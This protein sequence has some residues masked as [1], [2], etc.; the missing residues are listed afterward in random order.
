M[1]NPT[2]LVNEVLEVIQNPR[3]RE[4]I[5]RRFGLKD[6]NRQTLEAI[7]ANYGIT[8]ERVRQIEENG[9]ANLK[10]A[11]AFTKF[12]PL[13][14]ALRGHLAEHGD[15]KK[16]DRLYNDLAYVCYPIREIE[17]IKKENPAE[18][19]RCQAAFYLILTLGKDFDRV[20]ENE[21]FYPVWTINKDSLKKAKK[22]IDSLVKYLD[23]KKTVLK[24]EEIVGAGKEVAPELSE[25]AMSSYIDAS[26]YIEQN[27]LGHFGLAHWPEISPKGV[28]DR[29]FIILKNEG[30]PLHFSA[31]TEL[32]NKILPARR[33][34][35]VQTVHN[36]LIKDSR[37]V[38]VGRGLYALAEWG[39][40]PGTVSEII[41]NILK[42]EGPLTKETLLKKVLEKRLVK[43][44]TVLI[45]LQNHKLFQHDEQGKY[46]LRV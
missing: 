28:K 10:Q 44:N 25:K 18:L 30:R 34:A 16:E 45:N 24:D 39:Y 38:L 42:K 1:T 5:V 8:R 7:G 19:D 36:E 21:H 12:E 40:E 37:F 26:K 46:S 20:P 31:V 4:V 43:E 6:G 23:A 35:F 13:F 15:L 3:T 11:K 17:R 2:N 33:Q 27:T 32:I 14:E 22:A 29:A 41:G 9:L